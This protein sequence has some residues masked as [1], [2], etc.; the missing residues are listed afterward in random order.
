MFFAKAAKQESCECCCK[1]LAYAVAIFLANAVAF[2]LANA[3]AKLRIRKESD[4]NITEFFQMICV[5]LED[6]SCDF[7]RNHYL[8]II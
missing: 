7:I 5:F 4:F 8:C 3:A 6:N 1:F 2:F